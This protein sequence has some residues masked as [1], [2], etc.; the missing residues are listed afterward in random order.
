MA[1]LNSDRRFLTL[2][3]IHAVELGLL[4]KF[5]AFCEEYGLRYSLAGGTL[6]GAVR[7]KG[8]IPWDD[9]IDLCMPRPDWDRLV[10]IAQEDAI[11]EETG[12]EARPFFMTELPDT[13]LLKVIDPHWMVQAEAENEETNLWLDVIPVDGLPSD[14]RDL[15][16]LYSKARVLRKTLMIGTSTAESGHSRARRAFKYIAGPVLRAF[17]AVKY[18]GRALDV[19]ARKI[20]YGSTPYVGVL[21]WGLYGTGERVPLAGFEKVVGLEFEGREFSCMSCWDEYL[22]GIY[23]DYMQLPPEDQR[24]THGMKVWKVNY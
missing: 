8:F 3:E 14:E 2:D 12:F 10:Q 18:L 22:S 7:H 5:D 11:P 16:R 1:Q 15:S 9:D 17:N 23:G 19:L 20:P 4:L 21:T 24:V 13:P 6:L